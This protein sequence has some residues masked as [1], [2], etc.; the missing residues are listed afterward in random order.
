MDVDPDA[1]FLLAN[2]R[3]LLA[4]LRTSVTVQAGG[5]GILHFAPSLDLNGLIGAALILVGAV[6]GLSGYRRWAVADQAIRRGELPRRGT[7]PGVV[8]LAVVLLA[9]ILLGT[10]LSRLLG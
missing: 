6:C 5:V 8:A 3:T 9:I 2:E 4:W 1:R 7:G 10:E